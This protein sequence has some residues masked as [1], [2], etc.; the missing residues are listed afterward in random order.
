MDNHCR[1]YVEIYS[2]NQIVYFV[3]ISMYQFDH[4]SNVICYSRNGNFRCYIYID[5]L[6]NLEISSIATYTMKTTQLEFDGQ[7]HCQCSNL[8]E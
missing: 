7:H 5:I 8:I 2:M 1:L 6:I 4:K 3:D